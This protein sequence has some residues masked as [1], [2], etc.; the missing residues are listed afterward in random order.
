MSPTPTQPAYWQAGRFQLPLIQ[1]LV[2]GIVNTTPDSFSDGG[3]FDQAD[4]A[5]AHAEQLLQEGADVLDIGAE[6]TRPGAP[7]VELETE[8]SRLQPVLEELCR[9]NVPV[10]V[11]TKKPEVMRRAA[12]MGVDIINDVN[13]FRAAGAGHVLATYPSLGAV[14]MHMQGTPETMQ[15]KANYHD[16]VQEVSTFLQ[17]R[18]LDLNKDGVVMNRMVVDP[19]FGFGKTLDHNLALLK[20]TRL[21][22][23]MGAGV[24]VGVSRKSMVGQLT[25]QDCP[26]DRV[27]GSVAAALYA[28]TEG[29]QMV[30]VHDVRQTVDALKVWSAL[31]A[32]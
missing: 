21:F 15:S 19:G 27:S 17:Q 26:A 31:Q 29:A 7:P 30:R 12:Q 4:A 23:Q 28:V 10:S 22:S 25:G 14:I 9:W 32:N 1:P 18:L 6:S 11:D 16:V 8:W 13:G 5:I 24:L 20:A 2:M 3:L